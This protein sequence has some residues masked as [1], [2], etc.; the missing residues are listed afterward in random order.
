M[1][2]YKATDNCKLFKVG[3]I[4]SV[5][6]KLKLCENG[7][8]FCAEAKHT[9]SYYPWNKN[10]HLMRIEVMGEVV[11]DSYKFASNKIKVVNIFSR[12]EACNIL[13][14]VETLDCFG[15]VIYFKNTD[16]EYWQKFDERGN[17]I[18]FKNRIGHEEWNEYD[19]ENNLIHS[20]NKREKNGSG[21]EV[22]QVFHGKVL[23]SK[24]ISVIKGK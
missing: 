9:L 5:H 24:S 19:S 12:E 20:I 18:Y 22:S 14:I 16:W 2:A 8:H 3:N 21:M 7:Y 17:V 4:Y 23:V 1:N 11:G 6:G 10:F 13:G 15:N